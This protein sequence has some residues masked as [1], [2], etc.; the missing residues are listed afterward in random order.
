MKLSLGPLLFFWPRETVMQFYADVSQC[1]DI[2]TIYLGE[3]VCSRRQQIRTDDWLGLARD[4]ADA[5]KEVVLSAQALLKAN[6]T[7]SASANSSSMASSPSRPMTSA[8]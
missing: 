3:V 4:L 7:S 1:P 5:G 8:R 6:P 2:D